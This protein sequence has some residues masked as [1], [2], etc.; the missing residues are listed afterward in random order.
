MREREKERE[1]EI[2]A[3]GYTTAG[4]RHL[5]CHG[6]YGTP[7]RETGRGV[8][9]FGRGFE[10]VFKHWNRG[11]LADWGVFGFPFSIWVVL[12]LNGTMHVIRNNGRVGTGLRLSLARHA[13]FFS[14]WVAILEGF[15]GWLL[16]KELHN[17]IE[18]TPLYGTL[19]PATN[20]EIVVRRGLAGART[21]L[22]PCRHC[23]QSVCKNA[24][25]AGTDAQ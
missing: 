10:W 17:D 24:S 4:W 20:P 16:L 7:A 18:T 6:T 2:H 11:D 14:G 19:R 5:S 13:V 21:L 23:E 22:L 12:C 15:W 3:C 9:F 1:T 8:L 25:A